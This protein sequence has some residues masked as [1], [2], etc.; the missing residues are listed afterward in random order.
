M[1]N[2]WLNECVDAGWMWPNRK[3]GQRSAGPVSGPRI[4][5]R[6]LRPRAQL[7]IGR[8]YAHYPELLTAYLK[9]NSTV[10]GS[11]RIPRSVHERTIGARRV[12]R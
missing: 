3:G 1:K 7:P 6:R 2:V 4:T 11:P 9:L 5:S 10:T 12:Q 8:R